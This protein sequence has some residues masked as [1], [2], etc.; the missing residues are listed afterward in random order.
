MQTICDKLKQLG[1]E[2]KEEYGRPLVIVVDDVNKLVQ[3]EDYRGQFKV[4]DTV[5]LDYLQNCARR[6]ANSGKVRFMFIDS[7]GVALQRL[8]QRTGAKIRMVEIQI[9]DVSKE[10]AK[11]FLQQG[12]S[13]TNMSVDKIYEQLTG[14]RLILLYRVIELVHIERLKTF[15]VRH[16]YRRNEVR[17]SAALWSQCEEIYIWQRLKG[18][19]DEVYNYH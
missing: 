18:K 4:L 8:Q 10:Q 11:G 16:N 1:G 6:L 17:Q 7:A 5:H 12:L 19:I 13:K 15:D 9:P 14:G 2:F 3:F